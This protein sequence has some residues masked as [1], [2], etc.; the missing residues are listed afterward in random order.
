MQTKSKMFSIGVSDIVIGGILM[1]FGG[2]CLGVCW[3]DGFYKVAG[4]PVWTGIL[5]IVA[6]VIG[7]YAS[8]SDKVENLSVAFLILNIFVIICSVYVFIG[9]IAGA[10]AEMWLMWWG[11]AGGFIL[12]ILICM[13]ALALMIVGCIG[14][15]NHCTGSEH[16][17][18]VVVV[19]QT[20]MM[21]TQASFQVVQ[22]H[23]GPGVYT[24]AAYYGH[25]QPMQ[26][27]YVSTGAPGQAPLPG[28]TGMEQ[29]PLY[30]P[31][32]PAP[33]YSQVQPQPGLQYGQP[34]A[35]YGQQPPPPTQGAYK[36]PDGNI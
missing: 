36:P 24:N 11:Y 12:N 32:Q 3:I 27:M 7:I 16:R 30:T 17:T 25:A 34:Q 29:P 20:Q 19:N 9:A 33:P 22:T 13:V 5:A 15:F 26:P 1:F 31:P 6:G 28:T 14:A 35:Q 21:P 18:E 2:V 8:K 10:V 4:G 23:T